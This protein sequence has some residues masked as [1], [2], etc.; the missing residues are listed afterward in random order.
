MQSGSAA[1]NFSLTLSA[2]ELRGG[3]YQFE[4]LDESGLRNSRPSKFNITIKED[5]PPRVRANLLG[6]SGLVV[7][8]AM[9]PTSYQVAD[10]FGIRRLY[11][12]CV[13]KTGTEDEADLQRQLVFAEFANSPEPTRAAKDVEVLDLL[14]LKLTPGMSFRFAV[15]AEDT[16][17][18]IAGNWPF[19]GIFVASCFGRGTPGRFVAS[20]N[21]ATQSV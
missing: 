7:P 9:L 15:A 11:F 8:R 13:W 1:N 4:L 16:R 5:Q 21:R 19:P 12:D 3:E 6:I 20:G 18:E 2:E 10:E 17:P 14:P